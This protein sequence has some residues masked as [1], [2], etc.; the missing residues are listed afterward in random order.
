VSIR[1]EVAAGRGTTPIAG[2]VVTGEAVRLE[3]R[4]ATFASRAISGALDVLIQ[5][6][7]LIV[8]LVLT[9]A[10]VSG[11]DGAAASAIVLVVV[12]LGTV[13]VPVVVETL[14]RGRTVG[15]LVMGLRTVRDDGGPIRFRHA[16]V[17]GLLEF[18]EVFLLFG[19]PALICSLISPVGK[20]LGDVLAG[21]YVL[22]ERGSARVVAPPQMPVELSSWARHADMA[23]LPDGMALSVRQ[24]LGRAGELH[25][26]SR[27]ARGV[28]LARQVQ[29][30][31]APPPPPGTGA[32]AFLSAVLAERRDR[33]VRRLASE[34]AARLRLA[35]TDSVEAALARVVRADPRL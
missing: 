27:A 35:E 25:P 6:V 10:A 29:P 8:A 32:E 34:R 1:P 15:K 16:L 26:G 21:T 4:P 17:R 23:R 33:D 9:F 7:V 3:L 11:M 19:A 30:Y 2:Q 31:V 12:I 22:R 13:G 20:R 5:V 24:F 28:E 18:V 14:T